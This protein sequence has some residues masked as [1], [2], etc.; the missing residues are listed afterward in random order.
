MSTIQSASFVANYQ[1]TAVFGRSLTES[2][3]NQLAAIRATALTAGRQCTLNIDTGT[4][5][6]T[7][8]SYWSS[9]ED[10]NS[11]AAAINAFSPAPTTACTVTAV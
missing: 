4:D 2:E 11:Y 6:G 10:A 1:T 8:I 7:K 9:I 5:D 3:V